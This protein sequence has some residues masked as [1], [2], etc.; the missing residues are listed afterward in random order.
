MAT[1]YKIKQSPKFSVQLNEITDITKLAQ[2]L[3]YVR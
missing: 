2:L 1:N 3:E